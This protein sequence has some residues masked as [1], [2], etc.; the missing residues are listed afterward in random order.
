MIQLG[1]IYQLEIGDDK[2]G[3]TIRELHI[4]FDINKVSDNKKNS[5]NCTIQIYNLSREHQDILRN[6]FINA[7]F[8]IGFFK[9]GLDLVFSGQVLTAQTRKQGADSIT[10]IQMGGNYTQLNHDTISKF[11]PD[12]KTYQDVI[13]DLRK[14]KLPSVTSAIYAG[15]NCKN[16]VVDGYP[17]YGTARQVL[18]D[19]C[20][21]QDIEYQIDGNTLYIADAGG[22]HTKDLSSVFVIGQGSGLVERPYPVNGDVRRKTKDKKKKG[23][24]QFKCLI[25]PKIVCGSIIRLEYGSMTGYYKVSAIRIYGGFRENDWYM[26]IRCE[27]SPL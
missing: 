6:D 19:I 26:D 27:N 16:P 10:Q 4:T 8:S 9:T 22:S 25:N 15:V 23:G 17:M 11:I 24:I 13:E 14:S 20:A 2:V 18:D 5:N 7:N 3:F 21:S 12:G 1:R